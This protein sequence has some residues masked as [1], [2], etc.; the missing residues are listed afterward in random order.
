MEEYNKFRITWSIEVF[1]NKFKLRGRHRFCLSNRGGRKLD[2][3]ERLLNNV[4]V[5]FCVNPYHREVSLD[6]IREKNENFR[7]DKK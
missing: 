3:G 4:V 2:V 1:A 7:K 5:I 6:Y